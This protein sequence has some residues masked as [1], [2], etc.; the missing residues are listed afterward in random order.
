MAAR[1]APSA[2]VLLYEASTCDGLVPWRS[3]ASSIF[4]PA[5]TIAEMVVRRSAVNVRAE[6]RSPWLLRVG[7]LDARSRGL[8][9]MLLTVPALAPL[10]NR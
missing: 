3:A 6:P 10:W 4:T 2:P 5:D 9:L 1:R 7:M 8:S